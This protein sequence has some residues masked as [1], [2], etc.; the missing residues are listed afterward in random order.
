MD[1]DTII[2]QK[3]FTS[4]LSYLRSNFFF[5]GNFAMHIIFNKSIIKYNIMKQFQHNDIN[6]ITITITKY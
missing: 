3:F 1:K 2:P 6:I 5:F 4:F